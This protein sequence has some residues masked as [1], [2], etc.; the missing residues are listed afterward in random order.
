[1]RACN[2]RKMINWVVT[3]LD[4]LGVWFVSKRFW[5]E[6]TVEN[7]IRFWKCS[8][9]MQVLHD[10]SAKSKY[11]HKETCRTSFELMKVRLIFETA[12]RGAKSWKLNKEM[13]FEFFESHFSLFFT[14]NSQT[15]RF[16]TQI[17]PLSNTL[18][19]MPGMLQLW[20]PFV[21]VAKF[22]V[23]KP[24]LLALLL[25]LPGWNATQC[26]KATIRLHCGKTQLV[27][28]C[29]HHSPFWQKRWQLHENVATD[30]PEHGSNTIHAQSYCCTILSTICGTGIDKQTL[31]TPV[32]AA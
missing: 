20:C 8:S 6:C 29:Q 7:R 15:N 18:Q 11:Y 10:I 31:A 21:E 25:T 2:S 3:A 27:G 5:Y 14:C 19:W 13:T 24:R 26:N 1:M 22:C 32:L 12:Q 16:L 17:Q 9:Q 30:K 23:S 4:V 28:H